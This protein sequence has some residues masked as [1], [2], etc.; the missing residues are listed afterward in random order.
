MSLFSSKPDYEPLPLDELKVQTAPVSG[1]DI[2]AV[3]FEQR[4]GGDFYD[5][6]RVGPTRLLF[7]MLDVSGNREENQP[8][9]SMAQEKFE[10]R[11]KE[12]FSG[13]SVN[14]ATALT[15]LLL[16][17]NRAILDTAG[18]VHS[19]PAFAGCYNEELGTVCYGN[20]G[21][22]PGL[23]FDGQEISELKATGLPLGLFSLATIDAPTVALPSGAVLL[24][25]SR[26]IVEAQCGENE[27]G[28][29]GAESTLKRGFPADSRT[30]L[31]RVMEDVQNF[32]CKAPSQNDVTAL[33]LVRHPDGRQP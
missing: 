1:A 3:Y 15:T 26:G 11:G 13:D 28:L 29:E 22:T 4:E 18:R 21:H 32:T 5:F 2:A 7:G 24:L 19:C 31:T 16:E 10:S 27:F 25:V 12:L 9:L 23:I 17:L 30:L 6:L 33:A 20:A 8:I 14:E